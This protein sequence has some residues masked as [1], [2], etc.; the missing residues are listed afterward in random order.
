LNDTCTSGVCSGINL[1]AG[2]EV[3][4]INAIQA[5]CHVPGTCDYATGQCGLEFKSGGTPC[6]DNDPLTSDDVCNLGI[7]AG[8]NYCAMHHPDGCPTPDQ[9]KMEGVCDHSDG[10]CSFA[11]KPSG[12]PCDDG[13]D[14]TIEDTCNQ[15]VCSGR[16]RCR[17][18]SALLLPLP[19]TRKALVMR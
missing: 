6:N 3:C 12:T 5:V 2:K 18:L 13:S 16:S 1:C 7:C 17:V 10:S 19:V 11:N 8:T 4:P 14:L 15:G 9:C